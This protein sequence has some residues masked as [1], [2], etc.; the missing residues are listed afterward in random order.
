MYYYLKYYYILLI[1]LL[2]LF[3]LLK[4]FDMNHLL[5]LLQD[6]NYKTMYNLLLYLLKYLI[7]FYFQMKYLNNKD[8]KYHYQWFY[9]I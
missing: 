2:F 9:D 6:L 5:F 8:K 7:M 3:Y 1:V 4:L